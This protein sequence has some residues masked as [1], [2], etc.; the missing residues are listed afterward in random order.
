MY[1]TK[2]GQY[3]EVETC[4]TG[5]F[6]R[7]PVVREKS[8]NF[9]CEY[10]FVWKTEKYLRITM[11]KLVEAGAAVVEFKNTISKYIFLLFLSG[12][13]NMRSGI[14]QG[15]VRLRSRSSSNDNKI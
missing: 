9:V 15:K 2:S 5:A 12:E 14:S 1:Y 4:L 13:N 6:V 7:V 8:G 3:K 11:V 10:N